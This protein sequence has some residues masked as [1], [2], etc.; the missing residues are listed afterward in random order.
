VS[1]YSKNNDILKKILIRAEETA[2]KLKKEAENES[3]LILEE[4][5]NEAREIIN[6]SKLESK[7]YK[8][9]I[10][11]QFF[12]YERDLKNIIDNF[13]ILARKNIQNLEKDLIEE[14]NSALKQLNKSDISLELNNIEI[15]AKN[16]I[17]ESNKKNNITQPNDDFLV[18]KILLHD[19]HDNDGYLVVKRDTIVTL[20]LVDY[21]KDKGLYDELILSVSI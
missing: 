16:K 12:G 19:I 11:K 6:Q 10:T 13:Y 17:E 2:L 15:E 4:A 21:L 9:Q 7:A 3:K 20:Q 14:V 18:G 5:K 8:E 1:E